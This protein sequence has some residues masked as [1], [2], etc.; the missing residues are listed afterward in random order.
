MLDAAAAC[1]CLTVL[2]CSGLEAPRRHLPSPRGRHRPSPQR[3]AGDS[4]SG[5][6]S[7]EPAS[8]RPCAHLVRTVASVEPRF[9]G[10]SISAPCVSAPLPLRLGRGSQRSLRLC[11]SVL[12]LSTRWCQRAA[13][14][15]TGFSAPISSSEPCAHLVEP[16]TLRD[17]P[18]RC[19]APSCHG[20]YVALCGTM[21]DV[22]RDP[23]NRPREARVEMRSPNGPVAGRSLCQC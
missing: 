6:N 17:L 3:S 16:L 12:V 14:R 19:T 7:Q 4:R 2:S 18:P 8:L 13:I 15:G 21:P 1:L 20:W 5:S 10:A 9:A 23:R 22:L 11:V